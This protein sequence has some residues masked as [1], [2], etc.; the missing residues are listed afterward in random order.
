[1]A[2]RIMD[3]T[4]ALE[5][6]NCVVATARFSEHAAA[7]GN[8]AWIVSIHPAPRAIA[9]AAIRWARRSPSHACCTATGNW[10]ENASS[11]L[12]NS[13]DGCGAAGLR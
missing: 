3:D 4:M 2:I 9:S 10:L 6:G 1:M 12:S 8:G 7:D 13:L 5:I 11:S